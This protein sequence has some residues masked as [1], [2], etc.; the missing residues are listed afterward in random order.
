MKITFLVSVSKNTQTSN[1]MKI[2]PLRAEFF[3]ADGR[4]DR[5]TDRQTGMSKRIV[6]FRN[7]VNAPKA[8]HCLPLLEKRM[9]SFRRY[10]IMRNFMVVHRMVVFRLRQ[11]VLL[12]M[13]RMV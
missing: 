6:A 7:F 5:Q 10:V 9:R 4:T 3:H 8:T 12:L 2:R 13:Y 1:F 11:E